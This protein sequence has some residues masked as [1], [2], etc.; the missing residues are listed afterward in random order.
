M[1]SSFRLRHF[2]NPSTLR[3][4]NRPLL[5][6]FLEPHREFLA[7][8][9]FELTN[10]DDFDYDKLVAILMSPDDDTPDAMLDA[11]FFVDEMSMPAC[12]DDLCEEAHASNVDLPEG[13]GITTPELAVRLW[14]A[15]PNILE[16]L[17]AERFLV[18]PKSFE[19]YLST[20]SSLP[21]LQFPSDATRTALEEELNDFFETRKRGRGTRVF[22]FPREDGFW[23]LVRHGEPYKREATLEEGESSSVYYRPEKF[24]VLVYDTERG[25]LAIH[26]KNKGEKQAYCRGFGRHLFGLEGFFDFDGVGGKFTLDPI[27]SDWR[28]CVMCQDIDG[29]DDV[30]LTELQFRH[31]GSQYHV[32]V[33]KADEVFRAM[34]DVGRDI[35]PGATLLRA[36]FKVK[37]QTAERPRTL[38]IRPPNVTI[39]DRESDSA[40]LNQWMTARGFIRKQE[41][42]E[43]A[44]PDDLLDVA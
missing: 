41:N 27:V 21:D 36:S 13:D 5:V 29:I 34:E 31:P 26:A 2:S 43:D 24:D 22:P 28:R 23:F 7:G 33:H 42:D 19:Y 1:A 10:S 44:G 32:E 6:T 37:F 30:R 15:D 14:L 16:R 25:E 40:L 17:H 18:K 38:V 8:R 9:G 4:I 39:F 35:S 12:H 3:S 20:G 11:L